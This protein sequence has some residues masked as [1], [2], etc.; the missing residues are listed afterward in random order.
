MKNSLYLVQIA[1]LI[2]GLSA[3]LYMGY[4]LFKP[5]TPPTVS[6]NPIPI[7]NPNKTVHYGEP[8]LTKVTSCVF[9][10]TPVTASVRY[11]DSSGRFFLFA[12][13]DAVNKVGC[14]QSQQNREPIPSSLPPGKYTIY[15]TAVFHVTALK[16]V[17]VIYQTEEFSLVGN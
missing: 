7:L 9:S 8:I 15:V 4:L 13:H 11:Q 12:S 14:T 6:P 10:E 16:D 3:L 1:I 2:L 5:F 17:T